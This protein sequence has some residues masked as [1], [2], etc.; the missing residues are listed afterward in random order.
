MTGFHMNDNFTPMGDQH[1]RDAVNNFDLIH[2]SSKAQSIV[3]T[4]GTFPSLLLFLLTRLRR[5][6]W[7]Y[8]KATM[9]FGKSQIIA[10]QQISNEEWTKN[11]T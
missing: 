9:R 3:R 5:T 1:L 4:C 2:V 10:I 11:N 8:D 6:D 7:K